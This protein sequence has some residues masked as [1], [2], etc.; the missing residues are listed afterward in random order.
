MQAAT[1]VTTVEGISDI[2]IVG[3][4]EKRPPR[5]RTEPYIDLIFRLSHKAPLDWCRDFNDLLLKQEYSPKID[6]QEGLYIETWVRTPDEIVAQF[7]MIKE[8]LAECTVQYIEKRRVSDL[9]KDSDNDLVK[10]GGGE[11]GRLNSII[12]GLDFDS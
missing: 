12:A 9:S 11:Q 5:I 6:D 8:K 3:M 7:Q 1:R 2:K 10:Q 4:D